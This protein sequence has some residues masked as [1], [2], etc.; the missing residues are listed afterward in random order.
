MRERDELHAHP[1][2]QRQQQ[3][4]RPAKGAEGVGGLVPDADG[5]EHGGQRPQRRETLDIEARAAAHQEDERGEDDEQ[6][7][8]PVRSH[9]EAVGLARG[10]GS[11]PSTMA[12][13][14]A[15]SASEREPI[16]ARR[17]T[18]KCMGIGQRLY[19]CNRRATP[20]LGA[21]LSQLAE[22]D[23]PHPSLRPR[24]R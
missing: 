2:R 8:G 10:N 12:G 15:P 4:D 20:P 5:K 7:G 11:C 1:H 17:R 21:R 22:I 13:R 24:R 3:A 19:P 18:G 6:P 16:A 23:A 14:G 9:R